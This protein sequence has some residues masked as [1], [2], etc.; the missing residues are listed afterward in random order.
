LFRYIFIGH[1]FCAVCVC[2]GQVE[3]NY[4]NYMSELK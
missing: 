2:V 4:I 1:M 3:L